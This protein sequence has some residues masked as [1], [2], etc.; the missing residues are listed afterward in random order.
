MRRQWNCRSASARSL[1]AQ[2]GEVMTMAQLAE[3]RTTTALEALWA[4]GI[5]ETEILRLIGLKHDITAGR[6]SEL[7][8]EH[9]RLQ[10]ASYLYRQGIIHQ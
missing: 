4:A 2:V 3:P 8:P 9:K 5:T 7:T 1:G 10:F 6:R